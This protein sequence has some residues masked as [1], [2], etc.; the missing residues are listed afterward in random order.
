MTPLK[1]AA[2]QTRPEFGAVSAN[3]EAA[4][5]LVPADVE[6][7]VL[8][9]LCAT[10]YQ[11]RDRDELAALAEPL[12]GPVCRRLLAFAADTGTT[13]CA[14]HAERAGARLFNS[15][16]LARPDGTLE[17][18]RK[19]HLFW[20]ERNLFDAGDLGFPVFAACGTTVGM[21]VCYDWVYPESA[22]T[23]ALRG[24]AVLLHPSN[25]VLPFCPDAM[26][27]RCLENRVFALTANRVGIEERVAGARLEFIGTSQVCGPLGAPLA[28]LGATETGAAV[29][30]LDLATAD[31]RITP[32]NDLWADRRPDQYSL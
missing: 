15:A 12:D 10:G 3:L 18:F 5:A 16:V 17:V 19:I 28:R 9:E 21:M 29:A 14:G 4:L 32:L 11:F 22:R 8:P 6:L 13:L 23:L 7:A 24:A 2:V 20:N 31:K 25:L 26:I 30:V 27:T 1:V